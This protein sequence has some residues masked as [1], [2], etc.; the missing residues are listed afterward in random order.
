MQVWLVYQESED[1]QPE[2]GVVVGV[3]A[4][5]ELATASILTWE[6]D[7][8]GPVADREPEDTDTWGVRQT[9]DAYTVQGSPAS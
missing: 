8:Y 6:A 5:E 9:V 4:T 3:Y 2:E 1:S 7:V